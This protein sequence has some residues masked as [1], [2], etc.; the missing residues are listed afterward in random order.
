MTSRSAD[1]GMQ[2]RRV[3]AGYVVV[4]HASMHETVPRGDSPLTRSLPEGLVQGRFASDAFAPLLSSPLGALAEKL[5]ES[6][7]LSRPRTSASE[8][9][10]F[11][12]GEAVRLIGSMDVVALGLS[13]EG[14]RADLRVHVTRKDG[15]MP[16]Q[17]EI[18]Q[19]STTVRGLSRY[20][21]TSDPLSMLFASNGFLSLQEIEG[22]WQEARETSGLAASDDL[23]TLLELHDGTRDLVTDSLSDLRQGFHPGAAISFCLEPAKA[24]AAVYLS[25]KDDLRAREWISLLLSRCELDTVGFE[26][27]LPIRSRVDEI[28]V[29]DYTVRFDSERF[30]FDQRAEMRSAFKA[31]LGDSTLHVKVATKGH[32]VLVVLGGDTAAVSTRIREFNLMNDPAE[33]LH[34]ALAA[35]DGADSATILHTDFIKLLGQVAGIVAVSSG[36]SVAETAREIAREVGDAEAPFTFW[37]GD[38]ASESIFGTTFD[39]SALSKTFDAFK[40]SGL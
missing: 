17:G 35:L 39:L 36:R 20:I 9:Y 33:H 3:D 21:D 2:A 12:A 24:H 14:D 26:M 16:E 32:D 6:Y 34:R 15:V 7:R 25:A 22:S 19:V 4:E 8:L 5:N 40:G 31:F 13:V 37:S 10:E 29:E 23:A 18:S 11:D 1:R 27:A 38:V 28:M 30:D